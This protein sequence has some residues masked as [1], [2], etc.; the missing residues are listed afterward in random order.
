LIEHRGVTE[1]C[2]HLPEDGFW[3]EMEPVEFLLWNHYNCGKFILE[4]FAPMLSGGKMILANR[5]QWDDSRE[6]IEYIRQKNPSAVY[7][8]PTKLRAALASGEDPSWLAGIRT[9]LIGGETFTDDLYETL[10]LYTGADIYNLYELTEA[11]VCAAGQKIDALPADIGRPMGGRKIYILNGMRP[12]AVGE[13]G[14]ICVAGNGL[15]RGYWRQPDL[16]EEKFVKNP[17]GAGRLFRTGD[18]AR[19]KLNGHIEYLGRMD[20]QVRLKD[21]KEIE[22]ALR[23]QEGVADAVAALRASGI[24]PF[25][26]NQPLFAWYA[27]KKTSPAGGDEDTIVSTIVS[28]AAPIIVEMIMP[29]MR[30]RLSAVLPEHLIPTVCVRVSEIPVYTNGKAAVEWLRLPIP[31]E[32]GKPAESVKMDATPDDEPPVPAARS[33]EPADGGTE[34]LMA[35]IHKQMAAYRKELMEGRLAGSEPLSP[36]QWI[37][38][39]MG[40]LASY[41]IVTIEEPWNAERF[42]FVWMRALQEFPILRSAILI[43]STGD[44]V[45]LEYGAEGIRHIPFADLSGYQD[46]EEILGEVINN[47][48]YYHEKSCYN[49]QEPNHRL[50]CVQMEE[51][52]FVALAPISRLIFDEFSQEVLAGRLCALYSGGLSRAA[53]RYS[54]FGEFLRQGPQNVSQ[55]EILQ[56]LEMD[57][58]SSALQAHAAVKRSRAFTRVHYNLS[59][60]AGMEEVSELVGKVLLEALRFSWGDTAIPLLMAH[61]A[62][63]YAYSDFADYIGEFIDICPI[64]ID[65]R[66]AINPLK[67]TQKQIRYMREHRISIAA[68]LNDRRLNENYPF[69]ARLLNGLCQTRLEIQTLNP[70]IFCGENTLEPEGVY[71][72]RLSD[73]EGIENFLDVIYAGQTLTLRN[74]ECPVGAEQALLQHLDSLFGAALDTNE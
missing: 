30:E 42:A 18:L 57:A 51:K 59:I 74:L 35:D 46:K 56:E 68:L 63:N 43:N 32:N 48:A 3:N 58:F 60:Q 11:P 40:A 37:S 12:C 47:T 22:T 50:L 31:I 36:S 73:G 49:G 53:S 45:M 20:A 29:E 70:L 17:F 65:T 52:R 26:L 39:R 27:P 64:V 23:R 15:A 34:A 38:W 24:E 28:A 1:F 8:T 14:E 54:V 44:G 67:K 41:A 9:L 25:K 13:P 33:E 66:L 61:S 21:L 55:R 6:T 16:T 19:W 4:F 5:C 69:I 71:A 10:R 62:R 72:P 7:F 2:R